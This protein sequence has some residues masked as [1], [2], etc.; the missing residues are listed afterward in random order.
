M[1]RDNGHP[2][3]V[4]GV[5][6]SIA[7]YT[8]CDLILELKKEGV[9]VIPVLSKDAH[10]FITPLALQ[11][12]AGHEVVQDFFSLEGRTKPVHIELAKAAD[13]IVIAP[14]SADILARISLGLADDALSCTVLAA[15][16]PVIV[17]PAMNDKMYENPATQEHLARLRKRGYA[18]VEPV[19]G[20]LVCT[21]NAMGHIAPKEVILGEIQKALGLRKGRG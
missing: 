13:V 7:A 16:S 1:S 18:I 5:S 9:R 3:V 15:V 8:V 20:D 12:L 4:L 19:V 10:H 14:A 17:V 21:D 6:A 2:T 11:S